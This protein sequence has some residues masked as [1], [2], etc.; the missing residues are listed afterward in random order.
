MKSESLSIIQ[1]RVPFS[2]S[3]ARH[4]HTKAEQCF[5]ILSGIA[6][7]ELEGEVYIINVNMG[8][9]FPQA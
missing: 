6:I 1:E 4:F 9:I 8:G 2:C 5:F 3:E 7:M